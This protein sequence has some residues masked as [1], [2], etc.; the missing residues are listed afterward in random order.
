MT[1]T[2]D[3]SGPGPDPGPGPGPEL[4][5]DRSPRTG[6]L[7]TVDLAIVGAGIV[8]LAH[9]VHAVRRGLSVAV[10]ERDERA[11]G[12]SVRNFGHACLTVQA[13]EALRYGLTARPVWLELAAAAGFWAAECGTVAV[14]RA[15]D[16]LAVL[17]ELADARDGAVQLLSPAE[18]SRRVGEL[19]GVLG[20]AFLAQDLRVDP[21]SAAPAIAAW[22]AT[23]GVTFHWAT[24]AHTVEPGVIRTSRGELHS[25]WTV[26]AVG[27]NVDRHFPELARQAGVRRCSLHMLRVAAPGGRRIDPAIFSGSSFLRYAGFR[28]CPSLPQLRQRLT[29]AD[30]ELL[31]AEVN[32]MLTQL[33]DGDLVIGDTHTYAL[34]HDPFQEEAFDTLLLDRTAALLGNG[35]LTVH[36]R[37]RGVYA[38]STDREFLIAAPEPSIRVVSVVTGIGMTTSLGLAPTVLDG[39]LT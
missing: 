6:T 9:A 38:S 12:A 36:Q 25:T 34:T 11:V 8:G 1:H 39:L 15:Q 26:L 17:T 29:T 4:D 35:P 13:G 24:A 19:P 28:A 16:E 32:L 5:P 14:A 20:G 30:P 2:S 18:V 37:W 31:A 23:Q 33:P 7:G 10:V 27:H 3:P 22:L 21:R